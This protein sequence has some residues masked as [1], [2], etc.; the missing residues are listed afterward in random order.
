M[1]TPLLSIIDN[2]QTP[3]TLQAGSNIGVTS[4]TG[5]YNLSFTGT[6]P[7]GTVL[8]SVAF[9]M[10][11]SYDPTVAYSNVYNSA[12]LAFTMSLTTLSNNSYIFMSMNPTFI[13]ADGMSIGV[14]FSSNLN[15]PICVGAEQSIS[16]TSNEQYIVFRREG[17]VLNSTAGLVY[18]AYICTFISPQS[19]ASGNTWL[20]GQQDGYAYQNYLTSMFYLQEIQA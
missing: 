10:Q 16:D 1:S 3:I 5:A 8:Q 18:T 20:M 7:T 9:N 11:D 12:A 14:W 4:T 15:A 6:N 2:V 17:W 13:M 19:A